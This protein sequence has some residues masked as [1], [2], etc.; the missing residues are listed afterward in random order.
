MI[1]VKYAL[2]MQTGAIYPGHYG[3]QH[4]KICCISYLRLGRFSHTM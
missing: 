3:I 4:H 1:L 2:Y